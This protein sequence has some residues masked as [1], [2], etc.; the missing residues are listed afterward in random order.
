MNY[1]RRDLSML[2]P[3]LLA[4]GKA[5]SA[6]DS[7]TLPSK[8]FPI[9]ELPVKTAA[10]GNKTWQVFKGETHE[11]FP[12]DMHIT[13]LAPGNMPHPAHHHVHEEMVMMIEGTLEVTISGQ[14]K[15]IGPGGLAYVNSNDEHGWKNVGGTPARYYVFAIGRQNT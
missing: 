2:L 7:K 3:A 5:A 15:K 12:I 10:N 4:M 13:E 1:S 9:E 14:S 11:G 8:V 6:A